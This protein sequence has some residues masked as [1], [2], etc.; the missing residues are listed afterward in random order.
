MSR[1]HDI[2]PKKTPA[3]KITPDGLEERSENI[4]DT[5]REGFNLRTEHRDPGFDTYRK[6]EANKH[7][8]HVKKA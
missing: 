7:D 6:S 5:S 4:G 8:K 1:E 2:R 3:R